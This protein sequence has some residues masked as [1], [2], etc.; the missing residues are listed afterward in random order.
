MLVNIFLL[1]LILVRVVIGI[2]LFVT[3]R[4][5]HLPNL[6]WLSSSMFLTAITLLFAPS[7]GNPLG[8]LPVSIWAFFGGTLVSLIPVIVFNQLTF[9]KDKKSPAKWIW[10]AFIA[11]FA[12][13]LYGVIL[14]ESNY[15]QSAWLAAYIPGTVL[16]WAWHG[17]LAH[18]ALNQV[19]SQPSVEYWVKARYRLMTVYAVMLVISVLASFVRIVF[20]GGSSLT[21][22]GSLTG[23]ITLLGQIASLILM[24]LVWVMPESFR[25]WLNR[26]HQTQMEEQAYEQALA[27]LNILGTAMSDDTKLPKTLAIV[28]IRKTIGREINSE[29]S[30]KIEARV[31][32]LGYEDWYAFLNNPELHTFL[33]EVANVNP[34]D[35]LGKAKYILRENQSLFTLQ[36]K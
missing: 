26:N 35:V 30:K 8:N 25:L 9:Y 14:S 11:S 36:A 4:K 15:N 28:A 23:L 24:F 27:V 18:Q 2:R 7:E 22:L 10:I 34:Q 29:D 5:N 31:I 12:V 20:A 1:V 16:I 21:P 17:W 3:G 6:I 19:A 32:T 13:A 33:K